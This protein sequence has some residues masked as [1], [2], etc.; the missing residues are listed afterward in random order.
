MFRRTLGLSLFTVLCL[1]QGGWQT[2]TV[3]PGVELTALSA[4]NKN[5]ALS[6]LRAEGCNC[7]CSMKIAECRINDPP[8]AASRRLAEYV[9]K[10]LDAGK[11]AE[12]VLAGLRKLATEP[13]PLLGE[14]VK[15]SIDGDPVKGPA[16]ARVTVVEFSDFQCPFCAKAAVE[17]NL[18][19]QK[20]PN[21]IRV[22]FKQFPLDSHSHAALAG[23]ASLAAQAQGKFWEMH[24]KMYANFHAISRDHILVWAKEI[25]LDV[26][27][28]RAD[29]DGHKYAAR[30]KAEEQEGEKAGVEG[31]PTF[32]IDG[33][34]LNASF[35][36]ATV[37]PLIQKH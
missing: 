15:L 32:F 24:D 26:E 14:P 6:I 8:C 10:E 29:L 22:I 33:R 13:P 11:S 19:V 5:V 1:A 17:V 7:G 20:F 31:T 37:T 16:N 9:V 3:L 25:G 36:V 4:A 23:E 34:K 2:A 18:V 35:D 12:V 28:F 21:D 30:V 27:R